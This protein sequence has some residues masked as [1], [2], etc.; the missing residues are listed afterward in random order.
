M[1]RMSVFSYGKLRRLALSLKISLALVGAILDIGNKNRINSFES[2]DLTVAPDYNRVVIGISMK[3]I[4]V[5]LANNENMQ[6]KNGSIAIQGKELEAI[7][8]YIKVGYISATY[9]K[10]WLLILIGWVMYVGNLIPKLC[11]A[12]NEEADWADVK[13]DDGTKEDK[14]WEFLFDEDQLRLCK[15]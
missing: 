11:E 10:T 15:M 5:V 6:M 14:E 8:R 4:I 12:G 7:L 9:D 1:V 13:H 3:D 2:H